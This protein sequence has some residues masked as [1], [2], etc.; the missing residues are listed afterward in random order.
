MTGPWVIK[1][2]RA[3]KVQWE[4]VALKVT[5]GFKARK[6]SLVYAVKWDQRAHKASKGPRVSAASRAQW[7]Q[8]VQRGPASTP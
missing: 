2:Q 7:V 8:R 3:S 4:N 1:E 6:A 5:K